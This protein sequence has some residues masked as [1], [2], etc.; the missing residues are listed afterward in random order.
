MSRETRRR[1]RLRLG[2]MRGTAPRIR[3]ARAPCH[4]QRSVPTPPVHALSAYRHQEKKSP[5]PAQTE[6]SGLPRS[7]SVTRLPRSAS[8]SRDVCNTERPASRCRHAAVWLARGS[9][10]R[11]PCHP[12]RRGRSPVPAPCR[13]AAPREV[14][15]A[16]CAADG[17]DARER[18]R[19]AILA[20]ER[21]RCRRRA[22]RS[23]RSPSAHPAPC[24]A[25][26][27]LSSGAPGAV[28]R[29]RAAL[30][31][32]T[33]RRASRSRRS[34]PAHPAPCL[35]A[36][37]CDIAAGTDR[38]EGRGAR[39]PGR[40]RGRPPARPVVVLGRSPLP[41]ADSASSANG[42]GPGPGNC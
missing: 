11:A 20:P 32:R 13:A 16:R 24:L 30:L 5:R 29:D 35:A 3:G 36:A 31:R 19:N 8:G 40:Y 7:A 34:P 27:P 25:I 9:R 39:S 2:A 17:R 15:P 6:A 37:P 18:G 10:Q 14:V 21:S 38:A 4:A 41:F 28:P 22:S 26:A 12:Y 23:R 1:H 33:R 42:I